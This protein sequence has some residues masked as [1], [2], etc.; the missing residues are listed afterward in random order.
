MKKLYVLL[1]LIILTAFVIFSGMKYQNYKKEELENKMSSYAV[2]EK[3]NTDEKIEEDLFI[4]NRGTLAYSYMGDSL[5]E[6]YYASTED[7]RFVQVYAD[8]LKEKMGYDV[9]VAGNSG[10]G[11]TTIN[12]LNGIDEINSQNPD[13]ITIEFGTNDSDPQNGSNIDTFTANL[14]QMIDGVSKNGEKEP[15]IILVTTWYQSDKAI[16]FDNAIKEIGK[17]RG[18]PVADISDI[19]KDATNKGPEGKETF[20]GLS[21]NWHPNDKGM[22]LIAERIFEASKEILK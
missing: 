1:G 14:N 15:K 18:I 7:K 19:W 5:S 11:G 3:S 13:L 9:K 12:G 6:G 20:K 4:E 2:K 21:D 16:P 22:K 8:M 17:N 10:Y